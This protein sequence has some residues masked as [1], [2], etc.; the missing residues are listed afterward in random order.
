[1]MYDVSTHVQHC[2]LTYSLIFCRQAV[3]KEEEGKKER[4]ALQNEIAPRIAATFNKF[5]DFITLLQVPSGDGR[6]VVIRNNMM[7]VIN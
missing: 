4:C 2:I 3:E 5:K 1:M 6:D 7:V